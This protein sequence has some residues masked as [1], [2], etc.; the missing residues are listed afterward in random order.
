[1]VIWRDRDVSYHCEGSLDRRQVAK[2]EE[3]VG[4]TR[5]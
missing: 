4:T 3:A 2:W 1:M 5:H